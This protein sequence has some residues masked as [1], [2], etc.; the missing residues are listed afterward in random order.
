MVYMKL[1]IKKVVNEVISLSYLITIFFSILFTRPFVG[2]LVGPFRLGELIIG[3]CI[4][5][6]FLLLTIGKYFDVYEINNLKKIYSYI[7]I[8]FFFVVIV[9]NTNLFNLYAF[10]SSSYIWTLI[11][12]FFGYLYFLPEKY[13]DP[14]FYSII[15]CLILMY[16]ISTGNYPN[17]IIAFFNNV[18]D[19]FQF[20]KGSELSL[21]LIISNLLA[22][23]KFSPKIYLRFLILSSSIYF[24]LLLFNSRAAFFVAVIFLIIEIFLT[25]K[26]FFK[27]SWINFVLLFLTIPL[28]LISTFRVYGNLDFAK[29]PE[30]SNTDIISET[31]NDLVDRRETTEVFL[32]FYLQ[33]GRLRSKDSTTEWRLDIWQDVL[34]DMTNNS[35][36]LRGYGYNEIIP[37]M[38]DPTAPGRLGRDGMNENVHNYFVNIFARGSFIQLILFVLLNFKIITKYKNKFNSYNILSYLIPIYL[39]SSFDATLESVHFP[40]VFFSFLGYF[41]KK[42]IKT[43]NSDIN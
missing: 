8:S 29:L 12:I 19:K 17:F 35:I 25:R 43:K 33:D 15:I 42:G 20:L 1:K 3:G 28:F 18:S 37:V 26:E 39:M 11:F 40:L 22:K 30:F 7:V 16:I 38:L 21:V 41:L 13:N 6:T 23:N 31:V 24:P 27:I 32:S 10:K 36:L 14:F 9:T 2:V 34:E 4:L 5:L